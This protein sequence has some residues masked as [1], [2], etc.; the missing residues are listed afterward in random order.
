MV[1][2]SMLI[3]NYTLAGE[4]NY[5]LSKSV[6]PI[7]QRI[8][9]DL[10][11]Q[12]T[13]YT[14]TT[15]IDLNVKSDVDSIGLYWLGVNV[16]SIKLKS[17]KGERELT[18]HD[19]AYHIHRL[20]DGKKITKGQYQLTLKFSADFSTDALGLYRTKYKEKYYL[21]SQFEA[22]FAR[23]AFPI[24]DEPDF[25]IPYQLTLTVPKALKVATNTPV[26]S[27]RINGL[28]KTVV[29]EATPPMPSYLLAI[30]VGPL[31]KTPIKGLSVPGFIYSPEG[32]GNQTG[33]VIK[34]TPKI[35]QTLEQYFAID[36]PYRKLDFV[37][38]PDFAFGAME[39]PGLVTF[40]TELLLVGDEATANQAQ[41]SLNVIAHELAHMWY[42]DLVTMKW[43]DDLWLNE[44]FATWMAQKVMDIAYP[45]YQSDLDLPQTAA[46]DEDALAATKAIRKEVKTEKDI[47]DGMGLNYTK[48]HAILNMF[49]QQLG[50][51]NFQLSIQKY[52]KKFSWKNTTADDL[53][54]AFSEQSKQNIVEI[55]STY[56]DQPG[57]ALVSFSGNGQVTQ[58]RYK[59]YGAEVP[60]QT[61]QIPLSV[62][63]K[64]N[65]KVMYKNILLGD[66]KLVFEEA[67]ESTWI[68]PVN[69]GN[70]YFRWQIPQDKYNALLNDLTSLTNREKMALLSNSNGLLSSSNISIKEHLSLLTLLAKDNNAIVA[71][72]VIEELKL[73]GEQHTD[74]ANQLAFSDYITQVLTPW[75]ERIGSKTR[76]SDNDDILRL[77]PRLLRTLGQL[78]DN[79]ELNKE[80]V[81]L[82]YDYLAGDNSIDDNLGREALRI[83]AMLDNDNL[84]KLY[85]KTYLNTDNATLKSNI[86]SSLYFTQKDAIDYS[87]TE[88]FNE[89]IPAGDKIRPL[90][91]AFYINKNQD[92]IYQWLDKNFERYVAAIPQIYQSS[93]PYMMSPGCQEEN[94]KKFTEFYKNKGEIYQAAI[95]K[96]LEV[97][98]NCMAL[99][100]REEIAFN[101]FLGKYHQS[102]GV[103]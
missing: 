52:M 55:A 65:G 100:Q 99:K 71:L 53:W 79:P 1:F 82:A 102:L 75:Y 41:D 22:L 72:K 74:I 80:L 62:K 68:F 2:A 48:G 36:Y 81:A 15:L 8:T 38:V 91:G 11:P 4:Q 87:L 50:E 60:D 84:V 90:V 29:F 96:S 26:K 39:N 101:T 86:M 54:Q 64:I 51:D 28:K 97:E 77:R 58:Q 33:F 17:K 21:F 43:W 57:Y 31:D 6:Q 47:E 92:M 42:G 5:R 25:K 12:K 10:D 56:L 19:D 9:L 69:N 45:H 88:I 3:G 93:M 73:I 30:T 46:F 94:V 44:A 89:G 16:Q 37:A 67:I 7:T 35:L 59:N 49:E 103:N 40:R 24:F 83:A 27:Q 95:E 98:N 23:R 32:T 18:A 63:Y 20:S 61:W 14:G 76:A 70:G 78:G 85:Y 13:S 34:H 66:E